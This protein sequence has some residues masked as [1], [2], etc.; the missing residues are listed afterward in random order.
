MDRPLGPIVEGWTGAKKPVDLSLSGDWA[1][2]RRLDVANDVAGLWAAFQDAPWVWDYLFDEAPGDEASFT[3]IM[4]ANAA[5]SATW[6]CSVIR[7][8]DNAAP[9]G[10]A[11]FLNISPEM[12]TI[13]I[14]N[15]NLSPSLQQTPVATEA[16]FLMIDWAFSNGYR[17]VEWKCNALNRP[18]R[19]A[20]QRMGFSF[21]GV[22]RNHLVVKGRNR[23]TAWFAITDADW[24]ELRAVFVQW[25]DTSNFDAQGQ[26]QSSL[27]E[28]TR[29]FLASL[30]RAT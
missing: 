9:L 30:D 23:D 16:F 8:V 21:E 27:A 20:A 26:Q 14:G 12:G 17:R 5:K 29:P 2:L 7:A 19:K 25:L 22:F 3:A 10:Y 4:Q 13:E 11:C 15:V 6:P 18:S 28:L 1:A 24:I